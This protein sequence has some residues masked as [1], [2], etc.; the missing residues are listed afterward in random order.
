LK[1]S[2]DYL[3][4][5]LCAVRSD[6]T[7]SFSRMQAATEGESAAGEGS[8]ALRLFVKFQI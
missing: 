2:R 4:G 3:D 6:R 5:E 1:V 8:Q 7:T